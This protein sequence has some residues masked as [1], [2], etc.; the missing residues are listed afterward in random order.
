MKET[1]V[2]E[3]KCNNI[4]STSIVLIQAVNYYF[5]PCD[6]IISGWGLLL[7]MRIKTSIKWVGFSTGIYNNNYSYEVKVQYAVK[8]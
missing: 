2:E 7:S 4:A 1:I 8:S 6:I 3:L 5:W